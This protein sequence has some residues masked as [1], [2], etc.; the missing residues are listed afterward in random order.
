MRGAQERLRVRSSKTGCD[1]LGLL[2]GRET[3][4]VSRHDTW[5]LG[6]KVGVGKCHPP[7]RDSCLGSTGE[8][9]PP[10]RR[11]PLLMPP[12]PF[13]PQQSTY[14]YVCVYTCVCIY[15]M[16]CIVRTTTASGH[17]CNAWMPARRQRIRVSVCA[18]VR[19]ARRP[20]HH[21]HHDCIKHSQAQHLKRSHRAGQVSQ[22]SHARIATRG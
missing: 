22:C 10:Q 19:G 3:P 12:P 2:R 18:G 9:A 17:A 5:G 1:L 6:F 15:A 7:R 4:G 8:G 21:V 11:R 20:V 14:T 13:L 16:R